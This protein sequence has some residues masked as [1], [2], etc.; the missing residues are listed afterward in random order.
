MNENKAVKGY[1]LFDPDWMCRGKK[2]TCPGIF[3]EDVNSHVCVKEFLYVSV[4]SCND[5][6]SYGLYYTMGGLF[7]LLFIFMVRFS[8]PNRL[9]GFLYYADCMPNTQIIVNRYDI[10]TLFKN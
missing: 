9:L 10:I 2:Y 6:T 1:K 8:D 3:E 4:T 5:K 7:L